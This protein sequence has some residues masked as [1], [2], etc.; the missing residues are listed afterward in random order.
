MQPHNFYTPLR[1][2]GGKGQLASFFKALLVENRLVDAPYVEV[3]AGGAGVAF[4]LLLEH[5]VSHVHINDI[6]TSI[7]SFWLSALEHTDELCRL[8]SGSP[9]T[10]DN[11][12]VQRQIQNRPQD[13]SIVE[14][15][16]STFFLNRTNHSGIIWAG[17]IGGQKQTGPWKI[18]ARFNKND[19]IN[20]IQQIAKYK[21]RISIYNLDAAH[22]I[23]EVLSKLPTNALVY[24][25]PPYYVKGADLYE[26]HYGHDDHAKIANLVKRKIR[27]RWVVSYD[28]V[29]EIRKL[30]RPWP[31]MT[32]GLS[33]SAHDRYK[34]KE[35]MFFDNRLVVPPTANPAFV[36]IPKP[37][38]SQ[39]ANRAEQGPTLAARG[40]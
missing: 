20:R 4:S 15:G 22:F 12:R 36:K 18:D 16:F 26:H 6:N 27:Q 38:T 13:H 5:Y 40:T 37:I 32:Y 33:Y 39:T 14:L 24:L 35:V 11:W 31:K 7:Y 10:I 29:S 3:Y 25:D 2:P 17:V 30:Y 19:L 28:N 9:V 8:I 21:S 1:Y 23:Q 34:G